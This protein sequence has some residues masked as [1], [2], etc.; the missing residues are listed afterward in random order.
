M[1]N[2]YL[3]ENGRMNEKEARRIFQQIV[4]AVHYCHTRQIVHR[5]LKAENLL[6]DLDK[7]IKLADFGFSNHFQPGQ[8]MSTWCGSPPY[9]APELFEGR[10]YDG[11]K[12]DIWSMGVVLY[13][14]V[15]GA[16]PFDGSTLQNLRTRVI[17]GKFRIPFFM[18]A[19]CEHLIRHMLVVEPE[20]RL[21]IKQILNHR[22]MIQGGDNLS[23]KK[24]APELEVHCDTSDKILPLNNEVVEHML[25]LPGLDSEMIQRSVQ[26]QSFDHISAIY[27]LLVDKL[28]SNEKGTDAVTPTCNMSFFP[29]QRKT[30]I[31][32]G[33][34]FDPTKLLSRPSSSDGRE[35]ERMFKDLPAFRDLQCDF[36]LGHK[37]LCTLISEQ[38]DSD[39]VD[40][41]KALIGVVDRSLTSESNIE[42]IDFPLVSLPVTPA[43]YLLND[44]QFLEKF[45]DADMQLELESE[46]LQHKSNGANSGVFDKYHTA[47]R[48][49]VGPGDTAHEQ[50]FKRDHVDLGK[51]L[52]S[53]LNVL[54]AHYIKME[55][56][57][58]N[59][60]PNTNLPLNL[61]K[62]QHQPPQNFTVK[63]QHLLKP[64]PVMGIM[65]GFGRRAS[66]GG[67]NIQMFFSRQVEGIWSQPG[68]QEH[69]QLLQPGSPTPSQ[70][71]QPIQPASTLNGTDTTH[72]S[73]DHMSSTTGE[74]IPDSYAVARYMQCRGNSKRHTLAM[75]SAEEVQEAQRKMVQLQQQQPMRTRRT[76]LLTVMERPP[77]CLGLIGIRESFK[78]V[79]SLHLPQERYS[80]VR[81]ASEGSAS[82]L[83]AQYKTSPQHNFQTQIILDKESKVKALQ[84]EYQ[85]LQRHSG[86]MA[87]AQTQAELQLLHSLHIQQILGQGGGAPAS[88]LS[89]LATPH[90]SPTPSPPINHSPASIPGSPIHHAHPSENVEGNIT[91][92]HHLQHLH[93]QQQQQISSELAQGQNL[94]PRYIQNGC[95]SSLPPSPTCTSPVGIVGSGSCV[96]A[97][98]ITSITQGLSGLSTNTGS[99]THGIPTVNVPLD[100]RIQQPSISTSPHHSVHLHHRSPVITPLQL[101]PTNSTTLGMIQEENNIGFHQQLLGSDVIENI[102]SCKIRSQLSEKRINATGSKH[103]QTGIN[104]SFPS[105][106]PQISVTDEMGG[107]VTLV[108]SLSSS[109]SRPCDPSRP[110]IVRGIG[111][112]KNVEDYDSEMKF[113][114]ISKITLSDFCSR[115]TATDILGLVKRL[116]DAR[117]PPKGF[118]F[119]SHMS[120]SGDYSEGG[121]ALEYP[122]GVQIEL[123]C[124]VA[125][126]GL[127]AN[128]SQ[129]WL[130]PLL[131]KDSQILTIEALD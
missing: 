41:V 57:Q 84:Q 54:E 56:Q 53:G 35:L 72:I 102:L 71:S 101:S 14:L 44:S 94:F 92:A 114:G 73:Q 80:P 121:L 5:D 48:H 100:L 23:I 125:V 62:V 67:A 51:D 129:F 46:E 78:E 68:S 131:F 111:K 99:I 122:G 89:P 118:T 60:L 21:G 103:L 113:D 16:L 34:L 12:T 30:S 93:L 105:H 69:L 76:G 107:E 104:Q 49:T 43:V 55:G 33:Y 120:D 119:S 47:R 32:T 37:E 36:Q 74:D 117:A 123:M 108:E 17:K 1:R 130:N 15:C 95:M 64:P 24:L 28:K 59:I 19:D 63:D 77:G 4:A 27:H 98:S 11:P 25:R 9:A 75:A 65:G 45:G 126:C 106:H 13:V 29:S 70:R 20:K 7:D 58:L 81:R 22:W 128:S 6:L 96:G 86:G 50:L 3:V 66:D 38:I 97:I 110:S 26:S 116:I 87:D 61:P 8:K 31:T 10:E 115:L 52:T 85:Q 88:T 112:K 109:D 90:M 124:I 18:S 91:L 40:V 39:Y 83:G 127:G 42:Q 2:N 79:N 82:N